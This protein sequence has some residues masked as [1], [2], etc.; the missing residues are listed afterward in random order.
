MDNAKNQQEDDDMFGIG[1]G[2]LI[3]KL[4]FGGANQQIRGAR[5]VGWAI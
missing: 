2:I 1:A 4:G 5:Y 3:E